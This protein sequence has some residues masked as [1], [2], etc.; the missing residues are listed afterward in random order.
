MNLN[1]WRWIKG[2][3]KL[4]STRQPEPARQ[5]ERIVAMQLHMVLPTKA[6]VVAVVQ[7]GRAHV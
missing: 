4:L 1:A 2:L 6:G 3:N 7:I 5:A